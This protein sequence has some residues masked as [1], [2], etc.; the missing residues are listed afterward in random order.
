MNVVNSR[1]HLIES[2]ALIVSDYTSAILHTHLLKFRLQPTSS[3]ICEYKAFTM[4]TTISSSMWVSGS[5]PAP[6][7]EK[8]C[9]CDKRFAHATPCGK[10]FD[11]IRRYPRILLSCY[12]LLGFGLTCKQ[13]DALHFGSAILCMVTSGSPECLSHFGK[14][15]FV[16]LL[17]KWK[18]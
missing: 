2:L 6:R 9:D 15:T 3:H 14:C 4:H 16:E 8:R 12:V 1:T 10:S 13:L 7:R 11:V 5:H 17:S 18:T